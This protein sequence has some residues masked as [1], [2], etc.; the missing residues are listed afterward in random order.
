MTGTAQRLRV[1]FAVLTAF[2]QRD[3]MVS[4]RCWCH[5]TARRTMRAQRRPPEQL[6]PQRLQASARSALCSGC[7]LCPNRPLMLAT[8]PTAISH[9]CMATGCSAR[10]WCGFG[11]KKATGSK[12]CGGWVYVGNSLPEMYLKGICRK[13]LFFGQCRA[14]ACTAAS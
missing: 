14:D 9:Q 4:L 10:L 11:H 5:D 13:T 3:D 1:F 2:C 7:W 6:S 8:T 12:R